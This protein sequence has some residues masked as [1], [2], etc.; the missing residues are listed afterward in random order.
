MA[1]D[2]VPIDMLI[3]DIVMPGMSGPEL[4]SCLTERQPGLPVMFIS[5]YTDSPDALPPG[6]NLLQKPF[7]RT[8]LLRA[9]AEAGGVPSP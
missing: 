6:A 4:A 8:A 9:V 5:G 2:G 7:T 3:T 1:R